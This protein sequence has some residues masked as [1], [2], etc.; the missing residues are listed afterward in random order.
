MA[1]I[2]TREEQTQAIESQGE[3]HLDDW[4]SRRLQSQGIPSRLGAP[5]IARILALVGLGLALLALIWALSSVGPSSSSPPVTTTAP[6][7]TNANGG[8]GNGNGGNGGQTTTPAKVSWRD[9]TVDVLNGFG[10]SGAAGTTADELRT[11]GWTVGRTGNASGIASSEVVYLPGNRAEAAAVAKKL[12]LP[13]PIPIAQAT[14]VA[15]GSTDGVAIVL[16]PNL[17]AG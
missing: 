6:P 8:N 3:E 5:P 9:V 10:S 11:A 4:F 15:A 2:E 12:G 1:R 17:L 16:G 13:A 14:G 7:V